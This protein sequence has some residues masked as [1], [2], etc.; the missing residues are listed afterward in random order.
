MPQPPKVFNCREQ[1]V[2]IVG[3]WEPLSPGTER[4]L[5]LDGS[6]SCLR[7]PTSP[8]PTPPRPLFGR[9]FDRGRLRDRVLGSV[10]F[11]VLGVC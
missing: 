6:G 11:L 9:G 4:Y 8:N 1:P 10:F 3:S 2:L 5:N 7:L